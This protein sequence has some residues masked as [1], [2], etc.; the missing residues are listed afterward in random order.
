MRFELAKRVLCAALAVGLA[1]GCSSRK[2]SAAATPK[3]VPEEKRLTLYTSFAATEY[4][5][6]IDA[7]QKETG[8]QVDVVSA[9]TGDMLKRIEAEQGAPQGDVMLGGSAASFE[10]Y[11]AAFAPYKVR[12]DA[13]IPP[14][15]KASDGLWYAD[16]V[17]PMVIAYNTELVKESEKPTGWSE[18]TAPR[19]KGKLILANA[20]RSDTSF[21]QIAIVLSLF[22]QQE[23]LSKG[24]D[25]VRGIVRNAVVVDSSSLAIQ[26]VSRG[27]YALALTVESA[28]WKYKKTGSPIGI[29]YPVEGT[30]LMLDASAV[31]RG[32]AHPTSAHAFQDWLHGTRGQ[33]LLVRLGLRPV[34]PEVTAPA[35]LVPLEQIKQITLDEAWLAARRSSVIASFRDILTE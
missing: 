20:A 29:I 25:V 21:T 19:W 31:I 10:A 3:A 4:N 30:A 1:A 2:T 5:L 9:G 35:G 28:A 24:W 8:L 14:T 34:H 23:D 17:L 18:L 7:F 27:E 15:R 33:E 12:S 6:I 32:A 26:G 11:R 22:K 16:H 13:Q